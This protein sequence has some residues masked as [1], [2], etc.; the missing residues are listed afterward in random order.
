MSHKL[1]FFLFFYRFAILFLP[2]FLSLH[3][4]GN[5][6]QLLLV[7]FFF[8]NLSSLN[9][10]VPLIIDNHKFFCC[11]LFSKQFLQIF[12]VWFLLKLQVFNIIH[13]F[14]YPV[15]Q[16]SQKVFNRCCL[17]S[18]QKQMFLVVFFCAHPRQIP[19][20]QKVDQNVSNGFQIVTAR[21]LVA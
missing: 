13:I 1:L 2:G 9:F 18:F 15:R 11:Q 8:N 5:P 4:F 12:I 21:L 19:I 7:H 20:S 6:I 14:A 16:S 17:M 10:P 3:H